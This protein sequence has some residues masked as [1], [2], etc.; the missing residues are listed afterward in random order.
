MLYS[1][2]SKLKDFRRSAS[3][4]SMKDC[5]KTTQKQKSIYWES[6]NLYKIH[7]YWLEQFNESICLMDVHLNHLTEL[8]A[9]FF[10]LL[11]NLV[12]LDVSCNQ[13]KQ[14][15]SEGLAEAKYVKLTP[16]LMF[17]FKMKIK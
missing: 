10:V 15:P 17:P 7:R 13:L 3:I 9:D 16:T 1:Y 11:P 6:L 14:I 5:E 2:S 12:D 8:P 4:S